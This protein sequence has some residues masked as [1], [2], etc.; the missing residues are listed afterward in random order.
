MESVSNTVSTEFTNNTVSVFMR[1]F[2]NR[3]TDISEVSP[4]TNGFNTDLQCF[5]CYFDKTLCLI[6]YISNHKHAAGIR[7]V[8]MHDGCTVHIDDISVFQYDILTWDTVADFIVNR[9]TYTFWK[10][11]IIKRGRCSAMRYCIF[12]HQSVDIFCCHSGTN[13][14][15]DQIQH[16]V[17][18]YGSFFD[19]FDIFFIFN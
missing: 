3:C 1:K 10:A 4:R 16:T 19:P 18:N 7:I 11:L 8:S 6:V 5:F 2:L 9:C 15:A 12:M 17:V 13:F 14:F